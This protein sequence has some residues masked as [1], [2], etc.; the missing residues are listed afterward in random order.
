MM[1]GRRTCLLVGLYVCILA[2]ASA[3]EGWS[4]TPAAGL[5]AY[6]GGEDVSVQ[7]TV[8]ADV[9]LGLADRWGLDVGGRSVGRGEAGER[10]R[11]GSLA[12]RRQLVARGPVRLSVGAGG[13]ASRS[14][15]DAGWGYGPQGSVRVSVPVAGRGEVS[16]G[17]KLREVSRRAGGVAERS[18]NGLVEASVGVCVFPRG[19]ACT[20]P[21]VWGLAAPSALLRY[22]AGR[23]E[24][25]VRELDARV[26]WT[27][28]DGVTVEGRGVERAFVDVGTVAY[29]VVVERCGEVQVVEGAVAVSEPCWEAP[30]VRVEASP[31]GVTVPFAPVELRAA[32]EGTP[33]FR[34]RWRHPAGEDTTASVR[35]A[36]AEAGLYGIEVEVS[37]C[38]NRVAR[39]EGVVAV[40][41]PPTPEYTQPV[42]IP[43]E[44][45]MCVPE[46]RPGS[47][48]RPQ[49]S[50]YLIADSL[51]T[52][53]EELLATPGSVLIVEGYADSVRARFNPALSWGR[54]VV[55]AR[56][57]AL[58]L[59]GSEWE[60]AIYAIG[61]GVHPEDRRLVQLVVETRLS[62]GIA[63]GVSG[64][65]PIPRADKRG[66]PTDLGW[67]T[68]PPDMTDSTDPSVESG[69]Y[70]IQVRR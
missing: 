1:R 4:V 70:P 38:T 18:F 64:G 68:A 51:G 42:P 49:V 59:R 19:R 34:Y 37:N 10:L 5:S 44:L 20:G 28:G 16:L 32:V 7:S 29:R 14:S 46:I 58:A 45:G 61:R 50:D 65:N 3:Q 47:S 26:T 36:Y 67:P 52:V 43:F 69:P 62:A 27:F 2:P 66:C 9:A 13:L 23:F 39:S 48:K 35:V 40:E 17:T 57:V 60:G 56:E 6:L 11:A 24:L 33:P 30:R 41:R 63:Q 22:Q 12:L 21:S 15:S 54:A 25:A 8:G 31:S 55:V 53:V